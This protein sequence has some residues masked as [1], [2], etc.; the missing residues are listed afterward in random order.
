MTRMNKREQRANRSVRHDSF[1]LHE[2]GRTLSLGTAARDATPWLVERPFQRK[3]PVRGTTGFLVLVCRFVIERGALSP[4][5][6]I[7]VLFAFVH[8][9]HSRSESVESGLARI[10]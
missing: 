10:L 5:G 3:V 4:H 7:R 2:P 9:R 1:V 6:A 8:S